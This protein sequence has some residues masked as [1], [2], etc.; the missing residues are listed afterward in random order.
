MS[1]PAW[2]ID[3]HRAQLHLPHL[4]ATIDLAQ[5]AQGLVALR[6]GSDRLET[7][8]VLGLEVPSLAAGGAGLLAE[9]RAC[10]WCLTASY[11][12]SQDW[13]VRLRAAWRA[14][15]ASTSTDEAPAANAPLATIE[16]VVSVETQVL[17]SRPQLTVGSALPT[18]DVS[19]LIDA[20]TLRFETLAGQVPCAIERDGRPAC[21]LFRLPGS[22]LSYAEMVHPF[23]FV[24]DRLEGGMGS[25]PRV[26]VGHRL[27]DG[28]LEKGVI[29]RARVRG[30]F[31]Q[32]RHDARTAAKLYAAF[33]RAEPP[34]AG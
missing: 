27:F 9:C 16:L 25:Q 11:R 15:G 20:P 7:A 19:R 18:A 29:L 32:R 28:R 1:S 17:D 34:L 26:R 31:L 13:P 30:V 4:K 12:E 33:A 23:D 10:G 14:S 8:R 22:D 6:V 2:Q 21:L 3:R 24:G 5:P